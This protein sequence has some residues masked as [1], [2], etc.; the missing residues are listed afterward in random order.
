[1]EVVANLTKII[2]MQDGRMK[3]SMMGLDGLGKSLT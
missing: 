1:M 3:M 2:R